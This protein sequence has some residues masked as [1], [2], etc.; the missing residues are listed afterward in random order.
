MFYSPSESSK[1]STMSC[2]CLP[3][4]FFTISTTLSLYVC[5]SFH[6]LKL[7]VLILSWVS[8]SGLIKFDGII[9]KKACADR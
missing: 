7:S 5:R 8:L 3:P 9:D 2:F 4:N 6:T 1:A